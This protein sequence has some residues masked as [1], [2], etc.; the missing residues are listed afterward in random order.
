MLLP[1]PRWSAPLP[2]ACR[3]SGPRNVVV[4]TV[5]TTDSAMYQTVHRQPADMRRLLR[6]GWDPAAEAARRLQN[7]RRV[8][9]VG[10]GTSYHAALVGGWLLRAAGCDARAVSSFDFALYPGSF[11]VT[12]ED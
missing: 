9:V 1:A 11:A 10:I 8:F 12:A 2:S 6:D 3:N 4:V 7:V 5:P